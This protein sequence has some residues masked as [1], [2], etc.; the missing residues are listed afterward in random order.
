M[1]AFLMAHLIRP[2]FQRAEPDWEHPISEL[3][4]LGALE[5]STPTRLFTLR[6]WEHDDLTKRIRNRLS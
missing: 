5:F 4:L 2:C 1:L 3:V 6:K